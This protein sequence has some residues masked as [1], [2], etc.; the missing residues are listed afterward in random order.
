MEMKQDTILQRLIALQFQS[1]IFGISPHANFAAR[2][3]FFGVKCCG[4]E[5]SHDFMIQF[6]WCPVWLLFHSPHEVT[7]RN[8]V[9][10]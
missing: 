2:F 9:D 6:S 1:S 4:P 3:S 8:F 7:W 10:S 5:W